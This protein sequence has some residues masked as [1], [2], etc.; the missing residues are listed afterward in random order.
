MH[1]LIEDNKIIIKFVYKKGWFFSKKPTLYWFIIDPSVKCWESFRCYI[2]DYL[3]HCFT[4]IGLLTLINLRQ[5]DIESQ[6]VKTIKNG[7][8]V[9]YRFAGHRNGQIKRLKKVI[10][11]NYNPIYFH[12]ITTKN[13]RTAFFVS[14]FKKFDNIIWFIN[15]FYKDLLNIKMKL[16][17]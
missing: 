10:E 8:D 12:F 3:V 9:T 15:G 6:N 14:T 7:K 13:N 4:N 2:K 17:K 1:Q 5:D 11:I 16:Q